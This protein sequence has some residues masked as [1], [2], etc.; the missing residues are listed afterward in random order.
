VREAIGATRAIPGSGR[1]PKLL[2]PERLDDLADVVRFVRAGDPVVLQLDRLDDHDRLRALDV[3]TGMVAALDATMVHL[4]STPGVSIAPQGCV[5]PQ[6]PPVENVDVLEHEGASD[7]VADGRNEVEVCVL[8]ELRPVNIHFDPPLELVLTR[9]GARG[10]APRV[11]ICDRCQRTVR[12]WRFTVTWCSQCERW[13]RRGV[14]SPC[15]RAY[16]T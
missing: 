15:G 11:G 7:S 14:N 2:R 10:W 12:N 9:N 16:G 3:A 13:G 5:A 6:S 8:C 1:R 4:D